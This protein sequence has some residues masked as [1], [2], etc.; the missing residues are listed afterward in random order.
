MNA[1]IRKLEVVS[2][3]SQIHNRLEHYDRA[4]IKALIGAGVSR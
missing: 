2:D 1:S 3:G 4:Q